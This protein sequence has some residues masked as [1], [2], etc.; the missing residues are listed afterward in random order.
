MNFRCEIFV[1]DI[2]TL[3]FRSG[4]SSQVRKHLDF[5]K[6]PLKGGRVKKDVTCEREGKLMVLGMMLFLLTHFIL[7]N[8]H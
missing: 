4:F 8:C 5:A 6:R 7:K 1:S 2:Q 3:V